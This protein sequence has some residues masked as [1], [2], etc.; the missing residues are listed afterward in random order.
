MKPTSK[1][2]MCQY[3][4]D[5]QAGVKIGRYL[6]YGINDLHS[7]IPHSNPWQNFRIMR[8]EGEDEVEIAENAF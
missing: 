1:E 4:N 3:D 8:G 6:Y 2:F 7:T 5:L